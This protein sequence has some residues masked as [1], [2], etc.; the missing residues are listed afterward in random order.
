MRYSN[1]YGN[2]GEHQLTIKV[3]SPL[4]ISCGG[5]SSLLLQMGT[6]SSLRDEHYSMQKWIGMRV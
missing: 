3:E 1:S 6:C 2:A 4:D 5:S